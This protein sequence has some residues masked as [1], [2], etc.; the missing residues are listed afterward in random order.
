M[1][2]SSLIVHAQAL[3][4][5]FQRTVEAIDKKSNFPTPPVRQRKHVSDSANNGPAAPSPVRTTGTD[6]APSTSNPQN[7]S[8][9]SS[10]PT[11]QPP[12]RN[13]VPQ[14]N[15]ARKSS[16][17][18]SSNRPSSSGAAASSSKPTA[19]KDRPTSSQQQERVRVI[20]PELRALLSRKVEK[21]DKATVE[22]H[23]GGIGS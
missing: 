20:S 21:L 15:D 12:A 9:S 16:R 11:K 10:A 3:F 19:P 13:N 5:R 2:V 4:R 23:G 7:S 6:V 8:S 1:D 18:N 17:S 22:A 14:S